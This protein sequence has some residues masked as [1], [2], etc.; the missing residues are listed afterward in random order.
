[1]AHIM[2]HH[3]ARA[4]IPTHQHG[5]KATW[6][7]LF[8][9]LAFV[10][11]VAQLSGAYAHH[12]SLTGAALFAAAFLAM[13]WCWLGHTFHGTRFDQDLPRQRFVG[14]LQI[15]AVVLMGYGSS[16]P[17]TDRAW[18]FGTAMAAFKLLL[19]W[20][21]LSERRWRGAA[22][23]IRAYASL[24]GVQALLWL[25]GV[26]LEGPAR[27]VCW[28]MALMLDMLSPWMVA[29]HTVAVPPH[30]EHLP[31]RFGLFTII[32]LGEGM[33]SVVHALDHGNPLHDSAIASALLGAVLTFALW[34]AYFDRVKGYGERHVSSAQAGRSMRL[35]A[36]A[37]VPLYMGIASLAA[38]T[39]ALAA[40]DALGATTGAIYLGG[41]TLALLGL[42]LLG[43]AGSHQPTH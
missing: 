34:Q 37:H 13:W 15:G 28:G 14:F 43:R 1:M 3:A 24:Y 17:L 10:V 31:E 6:F 11:A 27:W 41:L 33:A 39:V 7:E 30:P 16:A 9:D 12:Y 2:N 22:G 4:D 26:A 29:R 5:R 32:L 21:Y 35:W 38:G 25:A 36:Y 18:A 23:L 19:A 8:F 40:P 20:A 42:A